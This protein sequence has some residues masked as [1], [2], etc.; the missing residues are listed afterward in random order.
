MKTSIDFRLYLITDRA[1]CA[2]RALDDVVRDACAAGVRAVQLRDKD[3]DAEEVSRL[4]AIA[5]GHGAGLFV[6]ARTLAHMEPPPGIDGLHFPDHPHV[7]N[8]G[9]TPLLVGRSVHSLEAATASSGVDFLLFSPVFTPISK[10]SHTPP[11]GVAALAAVARAV[12]VPVF[13][14]GG[15]T[16]DNARACI[17]A[18]AHGVAIVGAIMGATDVAA[19]VRRFADALG[20]AL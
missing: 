19:E 16:P 2:P 11:R 4:C 13:A 15:V 17:D 5:H 20:G 18:G 9:E 6:N 3:T 8:C 1:R 7:L 10:I 14:L 12:D